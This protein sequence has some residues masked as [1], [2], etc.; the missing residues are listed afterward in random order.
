MKRKIYQRIRYYSE[1]EYK[2]F[3]CDIKGTKKLIVSQ[4]LT[5]LLTGIK[6]ILQ[7]SS[8]NI[9]RRVSKKHLLYLTHYLSNKQIMVF[10]IIFVPLFVY[11]LLL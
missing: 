6:D 2:R 4:L 9:K 10:F 8:N 1:R 11:L 3:S 5:T 7:V